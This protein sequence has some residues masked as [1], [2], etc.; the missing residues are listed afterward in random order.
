MSGFYYRFASCRCGW[1][2]AFRLLV[3]VIS[4]GFLCSCAEKS[5]DVVIQEFVRGDWLMAFGSTTTRSVRIEDSA[6]VDRNSSVVLL[7][8]AWKAG[9]DLE[10]TILTTVPQRT[11]RAKVVA[12]KDGSAMWFTNPSSGETLI[13]FSRVR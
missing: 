11:F 9:D 13:S 4:S 8:I 7:R 5:R 2:G 1:F 12:K 10:Y 6:V 3:L